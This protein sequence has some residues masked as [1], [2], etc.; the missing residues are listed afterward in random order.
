MAWITVGVLLVVIALVIARLARSAA[1]RLSS[2]T[3]P[4][5]I[6]EMDDLPPAEIDFDAG[7]RANQKALRDRRSNPTLE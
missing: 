4:S 3:N 2:P 1:S 5:V 6:V 7:I